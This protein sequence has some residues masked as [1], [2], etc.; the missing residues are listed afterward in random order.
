MAAEIV[1]GKE[2]TTESAVGAAAATESAAPAVRAGKFDEVA[3]SRSVKQKVLSVEQGEGVGARVRRSI[4]RPELRNL[5]PFLM[6]VSDVRRGG[7]RVGTCA[8][9]AAASRVS[10][11]PVPTPRVNRTSSA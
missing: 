4:G 8:H 6:L 10:A 2:A 3:K 7:L 1:E 5:Q 9:A 11:Q